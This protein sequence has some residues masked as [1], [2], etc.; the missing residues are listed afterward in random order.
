M[1]KDTKKLSESSIWVPPKIL[2]LSDSAKILGIVDT[3]DGLCFAHDPGNH[4]N[5]DEAALGKMNSR[6]GSSCLKKE[7]ESKQATN[8]PTKEGDT[9]Y[10]VFPEDQALVPP[11]I[12]LLMR[13]IQLCHFNEA[14]IFLA[15][16]KSTIYS[17]GFEC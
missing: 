14:D 1:I 4:T 3:S 16:N 9:K 15:R 13:Q 5:T 17:A 2:Y 8:S 11:Y 12:Y 6:F 7:L 10:I